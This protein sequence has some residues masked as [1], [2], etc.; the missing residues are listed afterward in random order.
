MTL[1]ALTTEEGGRRGPIASG[2]R[3]DCWFGEYRDGQR[4]LHGLVFHVREGA[5]AYEDDGTLWVPLGGSCVADA[6][7]RYPSY[8]R[9]LVSVGMPFDVHEGHTVTARGVVDEIFDPGP[10]HDFA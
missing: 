9:P 10:E 5:D 7:V 8:L 2:Y 6:V 4:L 3:P 1:R